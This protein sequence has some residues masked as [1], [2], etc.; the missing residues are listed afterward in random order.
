VKGGIGWVEIPITPDEPD[1]LDAGYVVDRVGVG[2]LASSCGDIYLLFSDNDYF[3][4][5]ALFALLGNMA[6]SQSSI[7]LN[8]LM[9]HRC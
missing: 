5:A 1:V 2:G 8:E 3:W 7:G 4:V 9:N 6:W